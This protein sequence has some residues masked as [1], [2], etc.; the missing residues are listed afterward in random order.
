MRVQESDGRA[1]VVAD[2]WKRVI[3]G[4][5]INLRVNYGFTELRSF[6]ETI[7]TQELNYDSIPAPEF[8]ATEII[9]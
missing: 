2:L 9:L 4:E 5:G 6:Q 3:V 1:Q 8:A 7:K